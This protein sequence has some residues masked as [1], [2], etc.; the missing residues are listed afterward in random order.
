MPDDTVLG[1]NIET[2]Q[3]TASRE[4]HGGRVNFPFVLA[5]IS[6][7]FTN[8]D[9]YHLLKFTVTEPGTGDCTFSITIWIIF[10]YL[11]RSTPRVIAIEIDPARNTA[12]RQ[13]LLHYL[14]NE[15]VTDLP[16]RS[17]LIL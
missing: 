7:I 12:S 14:E 9:L 17:P 15:L 8:I 2:G 10:H 16:H 11:F 4:T 5:L 6:I 1:N 3:R 13:W